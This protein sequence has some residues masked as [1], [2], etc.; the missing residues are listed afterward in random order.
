M[1]YRATYS[2]DAK[3]DAKEIMAYLAQFYASAA[4]DFKT[5]PVE[6]VNALKD[7][8]LSCPAYER[9]PFFRRMVLGDYLLFYNVD[10]SQKLITIHR[11]FHHAGN[12]DEPVAEYRARE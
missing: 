9:D 6:R 5:G 10:E 2:D 12:I 4:R 7:M 8:P 11:V 1:S 3:S